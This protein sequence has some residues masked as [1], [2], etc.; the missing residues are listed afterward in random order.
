M[1]LF[2]CP[3]FIPWQSALLNLPVDMAR[4]AN[5]GIHNSY[6][7]S[8]PASPVPWLVPCKTGQAAY[9]ASLPASKR[10][11]PLMLRVA[12]SSFG[13]PP[14][15][16]VFYPDS[17]VPANQAGGRT[18]MCFSSIQEGTIFLSIIGAVF[19]KNHLVV[20]DYGGPNLNPR[21]MGFANRTD[22]ALT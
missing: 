9:E 10:T 19:I 13:I 6:R 1:G 16:L 18:D 20:F 5:A 11:Q 12:G 2:K 15:D 14:R 4:R 3:F 21:R 8:S 22:V 17:P 7:T